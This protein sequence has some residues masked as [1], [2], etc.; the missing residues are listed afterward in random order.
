MR[1]MRRSGTAL[2]TGLA[3][4][5]IGPAAATAGHWGNTVFFSVSDE[6]VLETTEINQEFFPNLRISLNCPERVPERYRGFSL[7]SL[8]LVQQADA[9]GVSTIETVDLLV[10]EVFPTNVPNIDV[11]S[12]GSG[13]N[14][15][16]ETGLVELAA[17]REIRLSYYIE[18]SGPTSTTV[19]V[20]ATGQ[21]PRGCSVQA[22]AAAPNLNPP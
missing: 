20:S 10:D 8:L 5:V 12:N 17:Q 3:A 15:L 21:R 4:L 13:R 9:P 16:V 11:P 22:E 1:R 18:L 6:A 14:L 7:Q 19:R 2:L